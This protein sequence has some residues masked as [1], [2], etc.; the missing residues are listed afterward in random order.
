MR[1][2]VTAPLGRWYAHHP[3][4]LDGAVG[5]LPPAERE[6]LP[7]RLGDLGADLHRRVQGPLR[8]L[9]HHRDVPAT[10]ILQRPLAE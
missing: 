9:E 6:M 2:F 10:M 3:E 8:V 5:G 4:Q 1:I 7:D